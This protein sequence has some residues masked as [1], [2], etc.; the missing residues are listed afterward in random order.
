[1]AVEVVHG[2]FPAAR[3]AQRA[4]AVGDQVA[5]L[6][7]QAMAAAEYRLVVQYC[8]TALRAAKGALTPAL[9][10]DLY[11]MQARAFARMGDR[12]SCHT[13]MALSESMAGRIRADAEPEETSYVQPG[14][15][16]TQHAEA[17]RRLGDLAPAERYAH[18]AVLTAH[19]AHLRGQVHRYAGLAL[20]RAQRGRVDEALEPAREMLRRVRGMESGRL[21][22][23]LRS[24]RTA[25]ASRSDQPDVREFIE[26]ADAE[27]G[28]GV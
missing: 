14:L 15:L 27:L 22:D 7:N 19:G 3:G 13:Q 16:E 20:I 2:L 17:L 1:V 26:H 24:V 9:T 12:H 28:L 8:E 25:L 23:R 6:S 10:S 4:G 11:T 21:H 18:E 5:L